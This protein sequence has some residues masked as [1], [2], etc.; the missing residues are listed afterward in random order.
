MICK[1]FLFF[2]QGDYDNS[3]TYF[4][5]ITESDKTIIILT[6]IGKAMNLYNKANYSK[7]IEYLVSLIKED[8]YIN[9]NILE[10]LGLSYYNNGKLKKAKEILLKVKA[11]NKNNIK[12]L[13]YN[14]VIDLEENIFDLEKL[15]NAFE[16]LSL[17]YLENDHNYEDF[18][19]LLL[20]LGNFCL[21]SENLEILDILKSKLNS[22]LELG[23]MK[24]SKTEN[25]QSKEKYRKDVDNIRSNIF[26]FSAKIFHL[27]VN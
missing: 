24:L 4:S 17:A 15:N 18:A 19:F 9:E 14:F 22:F 7:A 3:E 25:K 2:A 27:K 5:N 1:G 8:N 23:E 11:L 26:C 16:K 21:V 10:M 6:K 13:L 12:V 20:K